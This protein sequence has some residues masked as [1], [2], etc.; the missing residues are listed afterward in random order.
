MIINQG[1]REGEAPAEGLIEAA[2]A[3]AAYEN[4]RAKTRLIALR[5]VTLSVRKGEFLAI[6]GPSGCGKTTF[7]NMIAGFVKPVSGSVKVRGLKVTGPGADRAMVFQNYALLPW[8]TVEGNIAF[9]MENRRGRVPNAERGDRIAEV[10]ELVGLRGFE[11]SYPHE[12]SG[13]MQQRVGIARALVTKP[14][15]LLMDEPFGAVD[16]M[17]REAMQAELE[18]IISETKQTVVFI[19]HSI[20][21]AVMLGDRVVVVSNRPGSIREVVDVELPRPRF[22]HQDLKSHPRF[23]E[24]RQHLW[25]LLADEALGAK[26]DEV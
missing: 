14:E 9:A 7:I 11:K 2:G 1:H 20:D 3:T 21:E 18:S 26:G 10:L 23:Q 22:A 8:R 17:T 19:T 4:R 5:D 16:A 25:N 24:I 15:I 6:V 12:L 13:G